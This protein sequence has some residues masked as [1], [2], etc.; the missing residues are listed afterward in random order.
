MPVPLPEHYLLG[1]DEQKI[2]T[3][4]LPRRF[5]WR[6]R[7]PGG[8][9]NPAVIEEARG[10]PETASDETKDAYPVYLNGEL[11]QTRVGGTII[12]SPWSTR[13]RKGPGSWSSLSLVVLVM[14]EAIAD[15]LGRRDG[16]LD[17]ARW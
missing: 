13:S 9:R 1:F 6:S 11:R 7:L 16:A 4:G 3:E 10:W 15:R 5:I 14:V 12:C 17:R 2:E 8:S